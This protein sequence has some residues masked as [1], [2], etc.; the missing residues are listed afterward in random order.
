MSLSPNRMPATWKDVGRSV[1]SRRNCSKQKWLVWNQE[2]RA[3]GHPQQPPHLFSCTWKG[4]LPQKQILK[5]VRLQG[6]YLGSYRI[7]KEDGNA[8]QGKRAS[9]KNCQASLGKVELHPSKIVHQIAV[10]LSLLS[11][12]P[13]RR[14]NWGIPTSKVGH[15]CKV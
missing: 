12:S 4:S 11:H 14:E 10:K 8:K 7:Y 2:H 3:P 9:S 13:E 1:V 6:L 5:P 15:T